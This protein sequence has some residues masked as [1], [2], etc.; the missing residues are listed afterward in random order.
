MCFIVE[1]PE[2]YDEVSQMYNETISKLDMIISAVNRSLNTTKI[3]KEVIVA[4][5]ETSLRLLRLK[6]LLSNIT[7]RREYVLKQLL[8]IQINLTE[9][10]N[11]TKILEKIL[12]DTV[13]VG[14]FLE[15]STNITDKNITMISSEIKIINSNTVIASVNLTTALDL[16][17]KIS[18]I[19]EN[20]ASITVLLERSAL[21]QSL[22][23]HELQQ[24]IYLLSDNT[25]D[26]LYGICEVLDVQNN[27]LNLL[28]GLVDCS[29]DELDD[30]LKLAEVKLQTAIQNASR[31]FNDSVRFYSLVNSIIL[32][33]FNSS[34]LLV[35]SN[36]V[37][38]NVSKVYQKGVD[39]LSTTSY[40]SD[41][42]T[43]LYSEAQLL[44][45]K[46]ESLNRT[47]ADIIARER[48]ARRLAN[49]TTIIGEELIRE[50]EDLLSTLLERLQEQMAFISKLENVTAI[51]EKAESVS[52]SSFLTAEK[53]KSVVEEIIKIV[54]DSQK[55]LNNTEATLLQTES[56]CTS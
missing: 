25:T 11:K 35:D 33:G 36:E 18:K 43:S 8:E 5:N 44:F 39:V 23:I 17:T 31:I 7:E 22:T 49:A 42:F 4:F 13:K 48:G 12:N 29:S 10:E 52:N 41:N 30:L 14:N 37:L 28:E 38:T 2:C 20:L 56:V 1:C 21:N 32:P 24:Y 34:K 40:L 26:L 51:V 46:I 16:A 27:T 9:V 53:Q 6:E 45:R 54:R 19:I 55:V 15:E 47:A 3:D 50:I